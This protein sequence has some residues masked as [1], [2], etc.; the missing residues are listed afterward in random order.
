MIRRLA[1][2][3]RTDVVLQARN[4]LYGISV[5][6]AVV[7]GGA[8]AWLSP[9]DRLAGT[10][11]MALLMFVGGS[12]LLY[13]MAMLIL[14][15]DDGTLDAVI[16]SPLRPAEYLLSKVITLSGLAALEALLIVVGALGVLSRSGAVPVPGP[17]IVLGVV[18]L[19]VMHVLCGLALVVRYRRLME[20]LI[21]MSALAT[22]MQLP[23]F[24]FVGALAHPAWLLIPTAAPTM[25]IRGAFT[26]LAPWEWVYAVLVSGGTLL[27]LWIFARR[28]FR[29]HVIEGG[30]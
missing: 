3:V 10:V 23:G 9:H 25:F 1:A 17:L 19:A 2:A 26:E 20:A 21:P 5:G 8:L 13:A 4:Q 22:L 11:P 7:V 24:Y 29:R 18:L 14:E 27:A 28:A 30:R 6:V 16:V 12:T 15:R